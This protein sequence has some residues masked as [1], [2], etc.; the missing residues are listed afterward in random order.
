VTTS[1]PAGQAAQQ[2]LREYERAQQRLKNGLRYVA[3]EIKPVVAQTPKRTLWRSGKAELWHYSS[4]DV[5]VRPPVLIVPSLVSKSYILDLQPHNSFV[6]ALGRAGLD[7]FLLDWGIPDSAEASNTLETYVDDLLPPAIAALLA[8]KE[9]KAVTI[10]GH[11]FGGVIALLL[12]AAHPEIPIRGLV[13]MATPADYDKLGAIVSL[14]REGRLEADDVIDA[15][16]NVPPE[17]ILQAFKLIKP[18]DDLVQHVTL[19]QNLWNDKFVDGFVAINTW[20]K[21]QIPFP[22]ALC[23]QV[24]RL[25]IR[26]NLLAKGRLPLGDRTVELRDISC[27]YLTVVAEQDHIVP[28][29]AALALAELVGSSDAKTLTLPTGHIGY[30]IGRAAANT[31]IPAII[32]WILAHSNRAV[33]TPPAHQSM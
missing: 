28:P 31:T 23:R 17:V 18:T 9:A 10:I 7:V 26:D 3:G 21:D 6:N 24:V 8:A 13:T 2:A 30:V 33:D 29:A 19:T 32:D 27:P 1:D 14:M 12:A 11:C 5:S 16:G 25:L 15:T 4:P 22:G 20:A